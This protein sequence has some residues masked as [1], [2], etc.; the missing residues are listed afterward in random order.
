MTKVVVRSAL[1][2]L[3][4]LVLCGSVGAEETDTRADGFRVLSW[5][6]SG[7]AFVS[8]PDAFSSV[9]SWAGPDVL[10]LDEVAPSVDAGLLRSML[11]RL[12]PGDNDDWHIDIGP[13]GGRQRG[14]IAARG[15]LTVPPEFAKIIPYPESDKQR[16][17]AEMQPAER[18]NPAWSMDHGIPV[19]GAVLEAGGRRLLVVIADLQCCG[20]GP[21]SWQEM[22]RRIEA[23]EI[24]TLI[25]R[26]V[27]RQAVDGI[28]LAGDF[29]MVA[30]T[31][32]V[33]LLTGPYPLPHA[34]LTPAELYHIDGTET[35]TWDGRGTPF[36]S[37]TLDYQ[38]YSS[39]SL[40]LLSG[41]ILDTEGAPSDVRKAIGFKQDASRRTG[42][43]RPLSAEYAWQ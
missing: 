42:R 22:R 20:H 28:I 19:H 32:P 6:V 1:V 27:E 33:G 29:N 35:W 21:R 12:L 31:F 24:R 38:F 13:S 43:H 26:V 3:G 9:L 16:I 15:S 17:L 18:A 10:L 25:S 37:N 14:L 8:E 11:E 30:S 41:F 36:P 4:S 40:R 2:L 5:N 39:Q 23:R 34:G 7:D